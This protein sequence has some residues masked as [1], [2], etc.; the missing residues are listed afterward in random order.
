MTSKEYFQGDRLKLDLLQMFNYE[1]SV[2][3]TLEMH[4]NWIFTVFGNIFEQSVYVVDVL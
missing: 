4:T 2:V 3:S 1:N